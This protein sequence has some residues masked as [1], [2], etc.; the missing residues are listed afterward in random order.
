VA[1]LRKATLE[2]KLLIVKGQHDLEQKRSFEFLQQLDPTGINCDVD[3]I[4]RALYPKDALVVSHSNDVVHERFLIAV[5]A[6]PSLC[7]SP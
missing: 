6:R 1:Q 5:L 7:P 4:S 3:T 2:H